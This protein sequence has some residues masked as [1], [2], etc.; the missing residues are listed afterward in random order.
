M[1]RRNFLKSVM[2]AGAGVSVPIVVS[3]KA[4][5]YDWK[6]DFQTLGPPLP[7]PSSQIVRMTMFRG[8]LFIAYEGDYTG[9][10]VFLNREQDRWE[11]AIYPESV[12]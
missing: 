10:V 5:K 1:N 12:G 3:A 4:D 7:F 8:Q 6:F 9:G 2:I 11:S